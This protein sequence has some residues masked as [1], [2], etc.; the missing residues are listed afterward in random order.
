M[1][2]NG[3]GTM[4]LTA[5]SVAPAVSGT[6]IESADFNT[7]MQDIV[8]ALT[9]SI[10]KDGQTIITGDIDFD[11]NQLILD[12]DGDTTIT[13]DTDDRIDFRIGGADI[14]SLNSTGILDANKNEILQFTTTASA[15]NDLTIANAATGNNPSITVSGL[16]ATGIDI[17]SG[18]I[19]EAKGADIASATTTDIGAATGN[20]VDITGT[21]TITGLGTVKAGTKRTVQFDGSLTLTYNATSLILPGNVDIVTQAGD[22]AEFISLGSGNWLCTNYQNDS[23]GPTSKGAL[24]Y[25]SANQSIA[26]STYVHLA[27]DTEDEDT[28][29]IHDTVTNNQRLTV[30]S[31]VTKIKLHAQVLWAANATGYR[32]VRMSKNDETTT[33]TGVVGLAEVREEATSSGGVSHNIST[34]PITVAANDYFTLAVFQNSGGALNVVNSGIGHKTYFAMEIIA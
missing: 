6:L 9:Q 10:S 4:S 34:P 24:V 26:T 7:T 25:H 32:E 30:P 29:S 27:F 33:P 12:T 8:D 20:F 31:G 3:S 28:D 14:L 13:A 22:V 21:T 11:G 2:R 1:P 5:T 16:N 23:V 18:S 19:D 17:L 15:V